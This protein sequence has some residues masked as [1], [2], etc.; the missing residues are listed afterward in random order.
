MR[1]FRSHTPGL[2][3]FCALALT[4]IPVHGLRAG[5]NAP[6]PA[7]QSGIVGLTWFLGILALTFFIYIVV[8]HSPRFRKNGTVQP[9]EPPAPANTPQAPPKRP[10]AMND[11]ELFQYLSDII[12]R[13]QLYLNPLL[14]RQGLISRLGVSAHRIGAAFSKGSEFHSLPGFIRSL[15]LEHACSLLTSFPELSVKAV[16]ESSGFSNNSTFCSDFKT[17]YGIT[18]SD[19]RQKM[20][21]G[22]S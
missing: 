4:T 1:V 2:P 6:A 18:P 21:S 17:S 3:A 11:E 9:Q 12:R 8:T 13:E 19:Y 5:N 10:S 16:G 22:N 20:L 7:G 15:R 14:D